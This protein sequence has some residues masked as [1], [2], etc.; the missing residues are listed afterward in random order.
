[1]H[2]NT[3]EYAEHKSDVVVVLHRYENISVEQTEQRWTNLGAL[4]LTFV[5]FMYLVFTFS[6]IFI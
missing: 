6:P 4:N 2:W 1:M 3:A 5:Y